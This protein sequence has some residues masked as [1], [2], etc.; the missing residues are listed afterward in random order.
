MSNNT[1]ARNEEYKYPVAQRQ[2]EN[3]ARLLMKAMEEYFKLWTFKVKNKDGSFG[4]YATYVGLWVYGPVKIK[5]DLQRFEDFAHAFFEGAT[6][7]LKNMSDRLD[8]L[9]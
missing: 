4:I 1:L 2:A 7:A 6:E 5:R 8:D 9:E 3:A